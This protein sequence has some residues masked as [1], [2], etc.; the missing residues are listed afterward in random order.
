MSYLTLNMKIQ[1][2]TALVVGGGA[3]A[4]RKVKTLL[5]AGAHVRVVTLSLGLDLENL[6]K[7]A[8]IEVRIA[9]YTSSD[10]ND[11]F[12]VVAASDSVETNSEIAHDAQK[13]CLLVAV[14][15]APKLGNCTFPA[16]LQRGALEIAVSS[17]GR[18]PAFSVLVRD[19]LAGLIGEDFGAVL[20]QLAA[21]REKQ[22]TE[23]N[24]STY[25][26]KIVRTRAQQLITALSGTKETP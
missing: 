3:V 8:N 23:G 22:L 19:H 17:G 10:L 20:E 5:K 21:E 12:L 13:R 26:A 18:C 6:R 4:C 11:V 2:R 25:N 7:S 24:C 15:N 9:P 16:I 1:D 14:V